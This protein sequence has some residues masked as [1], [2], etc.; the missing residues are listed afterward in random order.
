MLHNTTRDGQKIKRCDRIIK[1][2]TGENRKKNKKLVLTINFLSPKPSKR[3][4][5]ISCANKI[6]SNNGRQTSRRFER[7]S[8]RPSVKQGL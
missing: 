5:L 4:I 1:S 6:S 2:K 3:M 7:A 8:E